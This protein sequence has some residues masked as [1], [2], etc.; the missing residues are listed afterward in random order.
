[1]DKEYGKLYVQYVDFNAS[2]DPFLVLE[3]E[4][5]EEYRFP[6][7]K[8][9]DSKIKKCIEKYK[10]D[11]RKEKINRILNERLFICSDTRK[12]RR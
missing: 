5:G 8:P 4:N 10:L 12:N 7:G 6:F 3:F 1:M 9:E 2:G 11:R